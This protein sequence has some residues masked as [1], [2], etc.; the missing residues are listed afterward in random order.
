VA[1]DPEQRHR[2]ASAKL[3]ALVRGH[4]GE[5]ALG[6]AEQA[7]H[8]AGA[9]LQAGRRAW[10][11]LEDGT[12]HGLGSALVWAASRGA[13]RLDVVAGS[14]APQL[15]RRAALFR[16]PPGVWAADG[17][18]LRLPRPEPYPP[19]PPER[20][21]EHLA[22][23]AEVIEGAGAQAV[24][25]AGVLRAEVLGL[26]VARVVEGADGARLEVGVGRHDRLARR[27]LGP[28]R[29][30]PAELAEAVAA[31]AD[32]RR[33]SVPAHPANQLSTE[34]WLRAVAVSSPGL[35]GARQLDPVDCP[36]LA[37]LAPARRA[38]AAALGTDA[39][40]RPLLAVFS[41]GVDPELVPA[42][43]DARAWFAR[44]RPPARSLVLVVPEGDDHPATAALAR[45][46]ATPAELR[47]VARHWREAS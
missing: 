47:K 4:W 46:L 38:P 42:A 31:V 2:L 12:A 45:A 28:T 35:A 40:G 10:V 39:D 24:W 3:A 13:E 44:W 25:E 21:P 5:A 30:G 43:A 41:T 17:R 26:E 6:G 16:R 7:R 33:G 23:W 19:G 32:R 14:R 20:P 29:P 22:S 37:P 1:L 27:S 36:V 34:R 8:P 15:A 9:A 11:L 18:R